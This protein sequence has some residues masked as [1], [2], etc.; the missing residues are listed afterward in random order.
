MSLV[1]F[2][3]RMFYNRFPSAGQPSMFSFFIV[4]FCLWQ[5]RRHPCASSVMR[6]FPAPVLKDRFLSFPP[7]A[8]ADWLGTKPEL[9]WELPLW[10]RSPEGHGFICVCGGCGVSF[11]GDIPDLPGQGPLQPTVGDPAWAG[12]WTRW[13]TEV[14]ANPD[15]SVILWLRCILVISCGLYP[16]SKCCLLFD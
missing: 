6:F 10:K 13:P 8:I 11:S 12:G 5:R 14:P 2:G 1:C 15:H 16:A 4:A 7:F 9:L 3:R